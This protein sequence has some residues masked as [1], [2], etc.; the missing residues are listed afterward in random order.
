MKRYLQA[1]SSVL[2]LILLTGAAPM[3]HEKATFAG[4]CFW[5]IEKYFGELDGVVSTR[6]GYTGGTTPN[7]SYEQ[8]CTGRTGHA[9]A[10]ELVY[11]PAKIA[12]EDLVEFFFRHHDATTLNRQG[13]DVGTQYRS[14]IF[15]H[16]P[17]Q[18]KAAR[19]A[20]KLLDGS[21]IFKRPITTEIVHATEFYP[22]ENYHQKYLKKNPGGYC[23]IQLQ[24]Q[25]ISDVL[26]S[27]NTKS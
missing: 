22:A 2:V 7:P 14:A 25:K 1:I 12:Y 24:P 13:N 19:T 8:V 11:D 21:G 10:I 18:E 20:V 6:V 16:T 4:G 26:R 23:N 27:K 17:E 15:Y 9:E 3:K 5:G